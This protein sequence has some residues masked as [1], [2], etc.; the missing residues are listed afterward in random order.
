MSILHSWLGLLAGLCVHV[1]PLSILLH[2]M[3]IMDVPYG[4][5][6]QLAG[7]WN[8][9]CLGEFTGYIHW[10]GF[11]TG[12]TPWLGKFIGLVPLLVGW[13]L[14]LCPIIQG[15]SYLHELDRVTGCALLLGNTT[16]WTYWWRDISCC[17]LYLSGA[18]FCALQFCRVNVQVP[19]SG[20][21][22]GYT[23]QLI[24]VS[25]WASCLGSHRLCLAKSPLVKH[26]IMIIERICGTR[27]LRVR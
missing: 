23:P 25:G 7:L 11:A 8:H 21:A 18:M 4:E 27:I 5:V 24:R 6:G 9:F 1:G 19:S 16:G 15:Q 17:I 26:I 14:K 13:S 12:W 3:G 2:W 10:Q 20:R 22:T